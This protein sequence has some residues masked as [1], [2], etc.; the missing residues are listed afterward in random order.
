MLYYFDILSKKFYK[1][2]NFLNKIEKIEKFYN[3][4]YYFNFIFQKYKK[5]LKKI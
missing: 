2:Y 3:R 5:N 1:F 4:I